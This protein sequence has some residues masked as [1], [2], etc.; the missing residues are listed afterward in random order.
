MKCQKCGK[1]SQTTTTNCPFCNE[2]YSLASVL[3]WIISEQGEG[4]LNDARLL[5]SNILDLCRDSKYDPIVFEGLFNQGFAG[6]VYHL[7][8]HKSIST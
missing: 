2:N 8:K 7:Y 3:A 1:E 5:K 6:K 4:I